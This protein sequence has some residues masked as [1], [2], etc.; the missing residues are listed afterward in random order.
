[1]GRRGLASGWQYDVRL[2]H[3]G[4]AFGAASGGNRCT[5][6]VARTDIRHGGVRPVLRRAAAELEIARRCVGHGRIGVKPFMAEIFSAYF[7]NRIDRTRSGLFAGADGDDIV[8][9]AIAAITTFEFR[10]DCQ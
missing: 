1:M 9:P 4:M 2:W 7:E 3:L 5:D 8:K 6:G 10:D